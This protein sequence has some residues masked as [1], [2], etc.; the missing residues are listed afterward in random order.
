VVFVMPGLVP[1]IL[2]LLF[3]SEKLQILRATAA[4]DNG[5]FGC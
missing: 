2:V 3:R 4:N 5:V 1:G